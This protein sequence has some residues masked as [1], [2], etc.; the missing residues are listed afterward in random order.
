MGINPKT[1]HT[2]QSTTI[3]DSPAVSTPRRAQTRSEMLSRHQLLG[4]HLGCFPF[5][6]VSRTRLPNIS[7]YIP[8]T[9]PNQPSL[10]LSIH[11][12]NG[13]TYKDLRISQ[14]CK[15]REVSH[16]QLFAKI[17]SL[18][19]VIDIVLFKSLPEIH[20]HRKK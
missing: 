13:S 1:P 19:L 5:G 15:L 18:L 20:D 2:S 14:L 9:W 16:R 3:A 12:E 6:A 7:W 4:R 8:V 17:P 11:R 10:N